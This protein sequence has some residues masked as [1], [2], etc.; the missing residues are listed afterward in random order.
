MRI[1]IISVLGVSLAALGHASVAMADCA[2]TQSCLCARAANRVLLR[3]T[4]QLAQAGQLTIIVDELV[5]VQAEEWVDVQVGE[6]IGGNWTGKKVCGDTALLLD[7]QTEVLAFYQRGTLDQYPDCPEYKACSE[8]TCGPK[9]DGESDQTKLEQWDTCD[10]MCVESTHDACLVHRPEALLAGDIVATPWA[11]TLVFG[12]QEGRPLELASNQLDVLDNY[13][14]CLETFPAPPE[15]PCDDVVDDV[16][17]LPSGPSCGMT[18]ASPSWGMLVLLL[19]FGRRRFQTVL[20]ARQR[21]VT[22]VYLP[23]V[24]G[25][26]PALEQDN[27]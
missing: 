14:R 7:P 4:T 22:A 26:T 21:R 15:P 2:G 25:K 27:Q 8:D 17:Q 19:G 6:Q 16:V 10:G 20:P 23:L 12:E 11:E 9:P 1:A 13:D 3:G 5:N 18:T 24:P